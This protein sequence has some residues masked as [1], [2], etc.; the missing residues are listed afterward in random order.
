[1]SNIVLAKMIRVTSRG[2]FIT[3]KKGVVLGPE[4][5]FHKEDTQTIKELLTSY[6]TIDIE[7]RT[8][9]DSNIV[10]LNL[11]NYDKEN[12][13]APIGMEENIDPAP[14]ADV[15]D[16]D[17]N[18]GENPV[19]IGDATSQATDEESVTV[20][21]TAIG[22]D[23]AAPDADDEEDDGKVDAADE[24]S[25]AQENKDDQV[26]PA[27]EEAP[28]TAEATPAEKPQVQQNN[29]QPSGNKR[30]RNKNKET[31]EVTPKEA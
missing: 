30:K 15:E 10:K 14:D 29:Q 6:P 27:V 22:N 21:G 7:E 16:A 12:D 18:D 25:A 24:V 5:F 8:E 28:K 31:T 2:R 17:E 19:E 13:R 23:D 4:K 26:A 20:D 9:K 11:S 3:K 1:M